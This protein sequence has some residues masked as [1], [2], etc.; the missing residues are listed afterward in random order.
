MPALLFFMHI[1]ASL[2]AVFVCPIVL[3]QSCCSHERLFGKTLVHEFPISYSHTEWYFISLF[4]ARKSKQAQ[5]PIIGF[6]PEVAV[7]NYLIKNIYIM[8]IARL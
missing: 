2:L 3:F 5:T 7:K 6:I 1:T 8:F 4:G